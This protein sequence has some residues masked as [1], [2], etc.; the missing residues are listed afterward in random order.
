[1]K[2]IGHRGARGLETENTLESLRAGAATGADRVEF[3]VWTTK[4]GVPVV[5][6][7]ADFKRMAGD[8]RRVFDI[9]YDDIK[10]LRTLDGKKFI[11]VD[12]A[13]KCLDGTPVY[14]EIKDYYLSKG[15]LAVL[16]KYKGSD[17]WVGSNNHKVLAQLKKKRPNIKIYAGTLWHPIETM[18]FIR[19]NHI[20]G[21]SLHY[22]WF[23]PVVYLF[24]RHYDIDLLLYTVN[25]PWHIKF[26]NRVYPRV[27][28]FTDFP[29]RAVKLLRSPT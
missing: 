1:V 29:D 2:I 23:N 7:D 3:D 9:T 16:D 17:I 28:I 13:L 25:N 24:C 20:Q 21:M 26:L 10:K 18:H 19:K 11:S 15:L 4:D 14:A 12:E 27:S 6:H 5:Q 8:P 22:R